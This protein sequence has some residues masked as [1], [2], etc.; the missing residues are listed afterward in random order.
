[1]G[2]RTK[3]ETCIDTLNLGLSG[4]TKN[5]RGLYALLLY[6]RIFVS[7]LSSALHESV[8]EI[9][10]PGIELTLLKQNESFNINNTE[11]IY[12]IY[13]CVNTDKHPHTHSA[14]A[15]Y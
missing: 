2:N 14:H 8:L 10:I 11:L 12:D 3:T 13:C 9:S 4:A 15:E 1:V 6:F 7:Q 5:W